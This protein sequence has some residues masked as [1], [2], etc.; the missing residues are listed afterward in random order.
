MLNIL[1][2][3]IAFADWVKEN[4]LNKIA[5]RIVYNGDEETYLKLEVTDTLDLKDTFWILNITYIMR[6]II[7]KCCAGIHRK[8]NMRTHFTNAACGV[9]RHSY[10]AGMWRHSRINCKCLCRNKGDSRGTKNR[11][12]YIVCWVKVLIWW[13][14]NCDI[15]N[16]RWW[17]MEYVRKDTYQDRLANFMTDTKRA[18]SVNN[19]LINKIKVT[20]F[21]STIRRATDAL[22][23]HR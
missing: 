18:P 1:Q 8:R 6:N 3:K 2:T 17:S 23:K 5:T 22:S 14:Y 11:F 12:A 13:S 21:N 15:Y 10:I 9:T 19:Y 20:S 7:N 4:I 16:I